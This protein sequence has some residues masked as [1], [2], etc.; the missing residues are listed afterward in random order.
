MKSSR[1]YRFL[2]F[3]ILTGLFIP[4]QVRM[5]PLIRLLNEMGLLNQG[6]VVLV[7]LGYS[8]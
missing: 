3:F 4:F 5:M 2:Y 7:Y 6:G 8:V 1:F